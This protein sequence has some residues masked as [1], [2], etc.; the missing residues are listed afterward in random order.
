[1]SSTPDGQLIFPPTFE[2][3]LWY[4][5]RARDGE[6]LTRIRPD[7]GSHNTV[8]GPDG[9]EAYLAGLKSPLLTSRHTRH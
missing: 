4:L 1:M 7:P 3:P 8:V 6:V 2:G 5:V 9:K